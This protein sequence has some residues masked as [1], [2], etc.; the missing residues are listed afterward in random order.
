MEASIFIELGDLTDG[1]YLIFVKPTWSKHHT[2]R[3]VVASMYANFQLDLKRVYYKK[4][5]KS[6]VSVME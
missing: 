2:Y 5:S 3:T 6:V 1:D 4:F